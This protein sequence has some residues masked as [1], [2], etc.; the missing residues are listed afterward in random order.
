MGVRGGGGDQAGNQSAHQ[1]VSHRDC[2]IYAT[3]NNPTDKC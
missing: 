1:L 2:G 3:P